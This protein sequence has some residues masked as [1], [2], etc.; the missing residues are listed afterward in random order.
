MHYARAYPDGLMA[1]L[2]R[3]D[4]PEWLREV[5]VERGGMLV[6]RIVPEDQ[7]GRKSIAT[8]FMQ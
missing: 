5:P 7:A 1:R 3:G 4:I 8:P 6:W 2:L